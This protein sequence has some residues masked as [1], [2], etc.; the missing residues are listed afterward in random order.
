MTTSGPPPGFYDDPDHP[1]RQR[2][3]DGQQWTDVT[4]GTSGLPDVSTVAGGALIA[5]GVIGFGR[6]RQ[7]IF[8]SLFGIALGIGIAVVF[9]FILG[10]SMAAQGSLEEPVQAQATIVDVLRTVSEGDRNDSSSSSSVTCGVTIQYTTEEGQ[11]IESGSSF[12]SSS[13][14]AYAPG[15]VVDITYDATQVGNFQGLDS[16]GDLLTRWFP[17]IFAGV[18]VVIALSSLWTFL[19]RATQIGGGLYLIQRSRQKDRDRQ[20]KKAEKRQHSSD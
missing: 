19:L 7:G 20:A 4:Q 9:G 3:W 5:D 15:Q 2:W 1:G 17:W 11:T 8:G 13:L 16:T 14:C 6:N 10:P 12:T 18:G